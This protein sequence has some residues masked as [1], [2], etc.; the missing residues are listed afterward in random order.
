MNA[1]SI[2]MQR[3][4]EFLPKEFK[5]TVWSKLKPYY[6]NL[7]KRR[8]ESV[9]E[10]ETWIKD[11]CEIEAVV[12]EAFSWRYIKISRDSSD[13]KAADLYRYA[14]QELS[15]RISSYE[16]QLNRKL[17]ESPFLEQLDQDKYFIY[18]RSISNA[19]ELFCEENIPLLT[20]VQLKSKEYGRIFSEMTIG[21]NGK[22]MT[23]Q[24]AGTILEEPDRVLREA[25]YHKIN[26]RIL[27]DAE[28]LDELFDHL[29]AKR[30]LI[31]RNAG[32]DNFRDFK[33]RLMGRFDYSADDCT[34]F[35]ESI[36]H[37]IVP[38]INELNE[39]RRN[40][41]NLPELRPWDL[42]VGTSGKALCAPSKR[43]MSYLKNPS[44]ASPNCT[45]LSANPWLS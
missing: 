1:V 36:R 37:E 5:I 22:Q 10:L 4:R 40:A 7:L 15:P 3:E 13:E 23:L 43:Q 28:R 17:V 44:I 11:R 33:F 12:M 45:L 26:S 41:L 18:V 21:F 39:Q 14:I 24:K 16:N 35:H 6:D 9:Q 42:H 32:F 34:R 2:P 29:L 19:V 20:E 38:L 31:A 8:I 27:Q 25:V 30:H